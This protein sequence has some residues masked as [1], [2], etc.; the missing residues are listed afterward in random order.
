MSTSIR[1][2]WTNARIP[3]TRDA[4]RSVRAGRIGE[5]P[6]ALRC[7]IIA[8]T[9]PF[10]MPISSR[11]VH[12]VSQSRCSTKGLPALSPAFSFMEQE[13]TTSA[14]ITSPASL[15][16]SARLVW[17]IDGCGLGRRYRGSLSNLG[18]LK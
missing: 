4:R 1:I 14:G 3:E 6:M 16:L 8:R 11:A 13:R 10:Q 18:E 7:Q 17:V 15:A 12:R 5:R 9:I 2:T